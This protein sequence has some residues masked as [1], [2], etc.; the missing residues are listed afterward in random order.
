MLAL[1]TYVDSE[2]PHISNIS[3]TGV[4]MKAV[5]LLPNLNLR[6]F[7]GPDDLPKSN[8]EICMVRRLGEF[9]GNG[10]SQLINA[11]NCL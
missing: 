3:F 9:I 1:D 4:T 8:S 5:K 2:F 6:V 10:R 11:I 7:V